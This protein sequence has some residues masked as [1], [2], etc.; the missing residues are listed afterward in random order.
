MA[1]TVK[2]GQAAPPNSSEGQTTLTPSDDVI[3]AEAIKT[4]DT[5]KLVTD[6]QWQK[7]YIAVGQVA[8]TQ[9]NEWKAKQTGTTVAPPPSPY[10]A[11]TSGSSQATPRNPAT[12][13]QATAF[14]RQQGVAI[15]SPSVEEDPLVLR[16]VGKRTNRLGDI[17]GALLI[18]T[19][20][21]GLGENMDRQGKGNSTTLSSFVGEYANLMQ[22]GSFREW[23]LKMTTVLGGMG[24][25]T[26]PGALLT[27]GQNLWEF[28]GKM[29]AANPVLRRSMTPEEWLEQQYELAGGDAVYEKVKSPITRETTTYTQ[30]VTSAQ[31]QAFI[32]DMSEALL[33]RLAN[34]AELKRARKAVQKLM[35]PTVTTSVRDATDPANVRSTSHTK[36][37]VSASDAAD[38]LAMRMKRS[39]EGTAFRA[40]NMFNDALAKMA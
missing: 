15:A 39:S 7:Y 6:Q 1:F 32:D 16:R 8:E 18:P 35:T 12:L 27:A 3:V 14:A 11:M 17:S 29:V 25:E 19:S 38:V 9:Y 21:R 34:D 37:G 2:P 23:M 28:A 10:P 5:S 33:G 4:G 20:T 22:K 13:A 26:K 36:T 24:P 31:A 30:T 40:G